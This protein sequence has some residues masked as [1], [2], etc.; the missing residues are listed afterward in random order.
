MDGQELKKIRKK[1]DYTPTDMGSKLGV[2]ARTVQNWE[3]N[4]YPIP[5]PIR[6]LI[7]ILWGE[8]DVK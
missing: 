8:G 4:A 2:S 6:K 1:F 7:G 3:A 5:R